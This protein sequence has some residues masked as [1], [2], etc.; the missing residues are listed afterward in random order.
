MVFTMPEWPPRNVF[1]LLL[2]SL[3]LCFS[4]VSINRSVSSVNAVKSRLPELLQA[5]A[6]GHDGDDSTGDE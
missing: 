5:R 6:V 3:S 4:R 1:Y 2:Y